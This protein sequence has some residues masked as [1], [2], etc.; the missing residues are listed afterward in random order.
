MSIRDKIE[1]LRID[2]VKEML[3]QGPR[4]FDAAEK[5]LHDSKESRKRELDKLSE[6]IKKSTAIIEHLKERKKEAGQKLEQAK[7]ALAAAKMQLRNAKDEKEAEDA[8]KEVER[9]EKACDDAAKECELIQKRLDEELKF[10]ESLKEVMR[11]VQTDLDRLNTEGDGAIR[12]AR[13]R[14]PELTMQ[15]Q[16]KMLEEKKRER[17]Y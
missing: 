9:C 17:G 5:I 6:E 16:Y 4:T 14:Y 11:L 15:A 7:S 10:R 1:A 8:A 13:S 3:R 12:E 2:E